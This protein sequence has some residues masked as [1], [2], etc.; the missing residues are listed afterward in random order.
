M[1]ILRCLSLLA[2]SALS[3]G[4]LHAD[5]AKYAHPDSTGDGWQSLFG[6]NLEKAKMSN[7]EV[8]SQTDGV[9]T[10]TKDQVIWADGVW[11]DF[12]LDLEFKTA[13][14]TNSGVIVR[15]SD[16][17]N[18][19]P[20]SLE[21]Q[22]ADDFAEKWKK[23][24]KTWQCGAV[25]GRLAAS[26]SAVKKPGEWNRYTIV[27][28]GPIIE[29]F[30]NSTPITKMDTRKWTDP[31]KNPDGSEIPKWLNK[32]AAEMELRGYIGLQGK[33][34]GAPIWFRNVRIK[35]LD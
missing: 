23:K 17:K 1:N 28:K 27:C 29:I 5:E 34:A 13:E 26:E 19:I 25:F 30:L 11:G 12:V 22:I 6:K 3:M 20:N 2:V 31:S 4:I 33:H 16:P 21:I 18:W 9:M 14:G 10:A 15:C 7:K 24:P 32:P 8:W 35:S